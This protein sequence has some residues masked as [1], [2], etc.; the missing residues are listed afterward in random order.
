MNIEIR[1]AGEED[2]ALVADFA[3]RLAEEIDERTGHTSPPTDD[4]RAVQLCR[5][6]IAR[7][8]YTALL[9]VDSAS[10]KTIG[11]AN[12][13]QSYALYAGGSFGI[14]QE[15]YVLPAYRSQDAGAAL[16]GA[17]LEHARNAGWTRVELCTPPIPEFARTLAF[18]ERNGY[19]VTGG[20]KM[21]RV[22]EAS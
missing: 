22:L 1:Q 11:V 6:L 14:I 21:K 20:R 2:A 19:S 13:C 18:Y 4:R 15:F 17:A 12:L 3:G 9:A 16:L 7:G 10:G 8:Q 5:E